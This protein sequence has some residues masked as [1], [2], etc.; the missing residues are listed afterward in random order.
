MTIAEALAVWG[1]FDLDDPFP[2]FAEL[3]PTTNPTEYA[4]AK[5]ASDAVVAMLGA[6]VEAKQK[7]PGDDLVSALINARDGDERLDS[8]ELLS[9]IFQLIVAGHDT[10]PVSSAT[11]SS[12][13]S[14]TRH[15]SPSC[16]STPPRFPRL[17]RSSSATTHR[18]RT[19]RF[20]TQP[21]QST[22]VA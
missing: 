10:T 20:A 17:S 8:Q 3:V 5:E 6:L 15:N 14:A 11:A 16:A 9:T 13:C 19:R 22:S 1:A 2:V 21:S 7:I 4:A 12:R 18:S